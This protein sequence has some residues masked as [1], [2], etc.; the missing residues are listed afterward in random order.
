MIGTLL[1]VMRAREFSIASNSSWGASLWHCIAVAKFFCLDD[2]VDRCDS[3]SFNGM[4]IV[5][6]RV[7]CTHRS[8]LVGG[9]DVTIVFQ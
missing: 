9:L 5:F 2:S 6:P 3:G 4:V 8:C 7:S 1:P